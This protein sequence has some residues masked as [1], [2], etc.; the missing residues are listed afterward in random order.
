MTEC[1]FDDV[2]LRII[3]SLSEYC[4]K[5][6][7]QI[8]REARI[9]RPTAIA[10]IKNLAG[11][12]LVDF[13]A[14]VRITNMGFKMASL[15]LETNTTEAKQKTAAILETC[16]RVL[17]LL[18]TI[19][20]P[21]YTALVCAE[22]SDTLLSVIECLRTV[23][24]ARIISWQRVKPLIGDSFDLK[25]F[26][27][28]CELTPCGKRCG[29]CSSYQE[30]ECAGCPPTKDYRGPLLEIKRKARSRTSVQGR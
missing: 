2:D 7:A 6:T 5:S 9:S 16:P 10:R 18:Q 23:L 1:K 25:I 8:A 12:H 26:F 3:K 4:R 17:Q 27:E 20:K 21:Y 14:K 19:E 30:S 13:G 28:K 22:D 15:A 11:E 29:L 24:N